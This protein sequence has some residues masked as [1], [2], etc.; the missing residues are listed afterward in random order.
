MHNASTSLGL[1]A[2][3]LPTPSLIQNFTGP[4]TR[5]VADDDL[6]ARLAGIGERIR[7]RDGKAKAASVIE[8]VGR[9]PL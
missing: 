1:G 8:S 6:K 2:D 5:L 9:R 4:S 7:A 3:W